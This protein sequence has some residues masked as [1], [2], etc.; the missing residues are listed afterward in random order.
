M[1]LNL[2]A[3]ALKFANVTDVIRD[4]GGLENYRKPTMDPFSTFTP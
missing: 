1:L 2:I 4:L 3:L